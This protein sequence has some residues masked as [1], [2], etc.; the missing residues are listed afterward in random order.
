MEEEKKDCVICFEPAEYEKIEPCGHAMHE[1]CIEKW[2]AMNKKTCPTCR[3]T[4]KSLASGDKKTFVHFLDVRLEESLQRGT[5]ESQPTVL[6]IHPPVG[7]PRRKSVPVGEFFLVLT[8]LTI[9]TLGHFDYSVKN[10]PAAQPLLQI[11][12]FL[13]F[14][15]IFLDSRCEPAW[16]LDDLFVH[17]IHFS[18]SCLTIAAMFIIFE[19]VTKSVFS[20]P[21]VIFLL[22]M[23]VKEAIN[24][25]WLLYSL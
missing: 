21:F 1:K 23:C 4:V 11:T 25:D 13:L 8:W 19:I 6:L 12:S 24:S 18:V 17:R 2:L 7:I 3:G 15:V 14:V 10:M 9:T 5:A 22:S 20:V 16:K